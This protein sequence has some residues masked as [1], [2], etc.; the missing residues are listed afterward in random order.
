MGDKGLECIRVGYASETK[1]YRLYCK[2]SKQI[3]ISRDIDQQE[4][5]CENSEKNSVDGGFYIDLETSVCE[6]GGECN[7]DT[8]SQTA[9]QNAEINGENAATSGQNCIPRTL[10]RIAEVNGENAANESDNNETV[11]ERNESSGS[12]VIHIDSDD[13]EDAGQDPTFR[14]RK[15]PNTRGSNPL[16][17][18][19]Q[20]TTAMINIRKF[21]YLNRKR[22]ELF[23]STFII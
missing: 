22:K 12:S 8:T 3:I 9:N 15:N 1:A 21:C 20:Q 16:N 13:D 6:A 4:N 10:N 19:K 17:L 18:M 14:T 11:D 23:S 5:E 2:S 7:R